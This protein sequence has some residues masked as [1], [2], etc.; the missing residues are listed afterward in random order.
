M[1]KLVLASAT[2]LA[3]A[4]TVTVTATVT[5]T[6]LAGCDSGSSSTSRSIPLQP[7]SP[8][9]KFRRD[10]AQTGRTPVRPPTTGGALW[11]FKTGKGIFSSPVIGVDGTIYIGSADRT[12][13]AIN[14][15][16]SLRWKFLTGE[17]IDSAALL[18]DQGRVYFGSGDGHVYALD[19]ATGAEVWRF[20]AD[21]PASQGALIDWFEGNIAMD[22]SGTLY[23]PCDNFTVYALD[24]ATGRPL[25]KLAMRDQTWS[26]PAIDPATNAVYFGNNNLIAALGPNLYAFDADGHE[27]WSVKDYDG[28]VA[29][30][31]LLTRQRV[32]VG[33]FDGYLRAYDRT[34]GT[35]LWELGTRD[36]IYASPAELPDGTIVQPSADGTVYAVDPATGALRWAFDTR[37]PLRSSPAVDGAGRIYLGSGEGRLYVLTPDG[38][39]SWAMRLIDSERKD[40][41]ASPA[42]G[43]DAIYIAGE[44]GQIFSVPYDY[45]LRPAAAGDARCTLGPAEDL[46]SDGAAVYFTTQLG[47][48]LETPPAEI[49]ANQILGFSLFVRKAGDTQLALIDS[50]SVT[51]TT[52]PATPVKVE[53]SGDRRFF[54]VV[55]EAPFTASPGA[56]RDVEV[57]VAGQ[58]MVDPER[59]GLRFSG[60]RVGGSFERSFHFRLR[61]AASAT[62]FRFTIP[63]GPGAAASGWEMKRIAAPMPSILP[64][65]NQIGFDS[66]HY[67]VGV[68]EGEPGRFVTWVVGGKLADGDN[69]TVVDP[70]TR[71]MFTLDATHRDGLLSLANEAGFSAEVTGAT[72]GFSQFRVSTR[73]DDRGVTMET[74][75]LLVSA[76]CGEISFYGPFLRTLGLCNAQ[77][78]ILQAFGAALFTPITTQPAIDAGT[79]TLAVAA[80]KVTATLTGSPLRATE[81]AFGI[82][83]VDA[84]TGRPVSLDYGLTMAKTANPD[85][86]V[87]TVSLELPATGTALPASVRAYLMVDTYPAAR[88]TLTLM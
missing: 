75:R 78:D 36:H 12:F 44:S 74:P 88:S 28:S 16:G 64:S 6:G 2:A 59:T 43:D 87:A 76:V 18:D 84:A 25:R 32:I 86:S 56:A 13:Y 60:G 22:A 62:P 27:L 48:A 41:N 85:G 46:P 70:A 29:A 55:P 69:H 61:E 83:L 40:L 17:I 39:L 37:A 72:L 5:V 21:P 1:N 34:L 42:L 15:D 58:Y 53:V 80:G 63:T 71:A 30:S 57:R 73:L 11:D 7:G 10:A 65:Y 79:V 8:W 68:V 67:L 3:A 26:S 54:T 77:T 51:V 33:N 47:A 31:P 4:I 81:H 24:R 9:P 19:A 35:T 50:P 23:A 45:C 49:D 82:L 38:K 20:H 52:V 14:R 66:L